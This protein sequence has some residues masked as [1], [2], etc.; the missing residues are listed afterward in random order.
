MKVVV[1]LLLFSLTLVCVAAESNHPPA[2]KNKLSAEDVLNSAARHYPKIL[3]SIAEFRAAEA[4]T[5]SAEGAFDLTFDIDSYN[6]AEGFY[7][8]RSVEATAS[9]YLNARGGTRV[10]GG[11]KLSNGS[12]PVYEDER[13]TNTG[14]QLN[15]GVLFSLLRDR[16][17]DPRRFRVSDAGLAAQQAKFDVLLTKL[18]I[19]QKAMV[20]YWRWVALGQKKQVYNNLLS[21]AE[22]RDVGLGKE[23]KEGARAEIV[24]TESR[25]NITQ[26]KSLLARAERDFAV[27]A[28]E[29]GM[30]YRDASGSPV[31]VGPENLPDYRPKPSPADKNYELQNLNRLYASR[32]ELQK[33][34]NSITRA[35]R[36]IELNQNSLLPRLDLNLGV[37][38]PLGSP[39]EGG[40]SRDDSDVIVGLQFSVP[41]ERRVA[42]GALAETRAKLNALRQKE[43]L[44]EDQIQLEVRNILLNLKTAEEL[45]ILAGDE[46][47]Q[48]SVLQRAEIQRF[49]KGASDFFLVNIRENTA[50]EAEVRFYLAGL[51]REIAQ[52]NFDAATANLEKL[53]ISEDILNNY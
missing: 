49:R 37:Y 42:R 17:I 51:Q 30:F 11:Y 12:F 5:L 13:F 38:Q 6:Y 31:F 47:N 9:R 50:A 25:Q 26:R 39:A 14:G 48:A 8:G 41:L 34:R 29:L 1:A 36:R 16:D 19:A 24:L 35:M 2:G 44:M 3:E 21:I 10:Y 18:G 32:P 28:N 33:L 52:V 45:L 27:A 40:L 22:K 43:R 23:V 15:L 20:A 4:K 7:D 46:V 53:G